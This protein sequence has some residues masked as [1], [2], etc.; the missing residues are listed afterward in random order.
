MHR[1]GKEVKEGMGAN[2]EEDEGKLKSERYW[3]GGWKK[4]T[5]IE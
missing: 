1:V 5:L 2:G 4:V 3:K